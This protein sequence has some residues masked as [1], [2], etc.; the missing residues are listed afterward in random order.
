MKELFQTFIL[1]LVITNNSCTSLEED[2]IEISSN[3]IV[4]Q[5]FTSTSDDGRCETNEIYIVD[6][7]KTLILTNSKM[8]RDIKH[9][10]VS[11]FGTVQGRC[12][13]Q[14]MVI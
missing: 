10:Q 12:R 11:H 14:I 1:L 3:P 6:G 9:I 4:I 13:V 8:A 2:K 5:N 7:E